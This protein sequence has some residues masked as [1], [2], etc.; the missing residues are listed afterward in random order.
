MVGTPT[1]HGHRAREKFIPA[2]VSRPSVRRPRQDCLVWSFQTRLPLDPGI[3]LS[4]WARLGGFVKIRLDQRLVDDGLFPSR[5]KA[6]RA[7]MA[8][9]V[10]INGQ[11]AGKPGDSVPPEAEIHVLA[12]EKYVSRGGR[13]LEHALRIFDLD[14]HDATAIDLGASTGGFTDCL[15]QAGAK[16]VFAVDVGHGQLAWRLRRDPRVVPMEKTNARYLTPSHFSPTDL[17]VDLVVMDCSFISLKKILSSAAA[18]VKPS[19]NIVALVKPQFEAG[20][21]EAGRGRGVIR[22]PA[23]HQRILEDLKNFA[24]SAG[25]L[26]WIAHTKSPLQGPA[27]NTEFLALL[28]KV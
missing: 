9:Q 10:R 7:I 28:R 14:V 3:I 23:I 26:Q 11:P 27:G 21:R 2:P 24:H 1:K 17:P 22:D 5:E 4:R 20:R 18:L 6:R 25:T 15:L 8:G 19:G 13:K 16:R 12:G